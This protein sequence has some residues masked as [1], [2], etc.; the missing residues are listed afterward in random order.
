MGI[1]AVA[2]VIIMIAMNFFDGGKGNGLVDT[3]LEGLV[4][5][6]TGIFKFN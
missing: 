3:L 1:A 2:V 5:G 4:S 6:V